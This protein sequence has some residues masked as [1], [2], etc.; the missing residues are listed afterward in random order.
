MRRWEI[1][2]SAEN[3]RQ[4]CISTQ[5]SMYTSEVVC[6]KPEKGELFKLFSWCV[7][8]YVCICVSGCVHICVGALACALGKPERASVC[9][10]LELQTCLHTCCLYPCVHPDCYT[11]AG[12]WTLV[13]MQHMHLTT[14]LSSSYQN[15]WNYCTVQWALN[16]M[17]GLQLRST[18]RQPSRM[19]RV[20]KPRYPGGWG[21]RI[22]SSRSAQAA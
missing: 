1:S 10:R 15:A 18:C 6:L 21:R 20:Y 14:K 22:E 12:I 3:S 11:C 5:F 9:L 13:I 2:V 16:Q 17:A 7:C 4:C 19:R 8:M